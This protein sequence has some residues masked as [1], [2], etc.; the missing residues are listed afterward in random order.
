M[1]KGKNNNNVEQNAEKQNSKLVL[2]WMVAV[3]ANIS[4]QEDF[5]IML[6]YSFF[7]LHLDFIPFP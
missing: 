4:P 7:G 1:T 5:C 3:Y 6:L 2:V